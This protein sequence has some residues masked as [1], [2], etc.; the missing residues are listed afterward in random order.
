MKAKDKKK[1]LGFYEMLAKLNDFRDCMH[2][3]LV[4]MSK[5]FDLSDH[6]SVWQFM[7]TRDPR[8]DDGKRIMLEV[9]WS[10]GEKGMQRVKDFISSFR[11]GDFA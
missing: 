2:S 3:A 6:K 8:F 11:A 10:D 5:Q 4:L 1:K 9:L 7:N